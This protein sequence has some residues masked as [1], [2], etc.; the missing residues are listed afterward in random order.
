MSKLLKWTI[1]LK[2]VSLIILALFSGRVQNDMDRIK[3]IDY[4]VN[5]IKIQLC[6]KQ[7]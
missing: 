3:K 5:A 6:F 1:K 7:H 4:Y 2:F